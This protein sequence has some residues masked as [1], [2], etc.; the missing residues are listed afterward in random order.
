MKGVVDTRSPIVKAIGSA[1]A[2]TRFT[3]ET[4]RL[5]GQT[6]A[7]RSLPARAVQRANDEARKY[8]A[9]VREWSDQRLYDADN[10]ARGID[11]GDRDLE[12]QVHVLAKALIVAP[13]G[14]G[15]PPVTVPTPL[16]R[17]AEEL[18]NSLETDEV[19]HLF[20]AWHRWQ[21]ER[22]PIT[23]AETPEEVE[24]FVDSLGKGVTPLS[25]L[26]SCEDGML[27]STAICMA[28]RLRSLMRRPSSGTSPSSGPDAGSSPPSDSTPPGM[29]IE[30]SP[31]AS[32]T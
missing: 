12:M 31:A 25:R 22:S 4:G 8:L 14:D 9:E 24:A 19:R 15:D 6:F 29:V 17:D 7:I 28:R 21:R 27:L 13:E 3:V 5:A 23:R 16:F 11:K 26:R 18:A 20:S 32:T 10:V 30:T 2:F 1:V